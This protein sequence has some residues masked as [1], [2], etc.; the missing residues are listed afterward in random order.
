MAC[1]KLNGWSEIG[2]AFGM[3]HL[4]FDDCWLLGKQSKE[5]GCWYQRPRPES[6]KVPQYRNFLSDVNGNFQFIRGHVPL[7]VTLRSISAFFISESIIV[8]NGQVTVSVSLRRIIG[9]TLL[10]SSI[11][12]FFKLAELA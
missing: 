12:L 5:T 4:V 6:F 10:E 1:S 9:I 11:E 8:C 3:G 7:N 2:F